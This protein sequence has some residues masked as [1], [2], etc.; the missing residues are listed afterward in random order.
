MLLQAPL[1]FV[2]GGVVNDNSLYDIN[3]FGRHW[4]KI[5]NSGMFAYNLAFSNSI[6]YSSTYDIR[7]AGISLRCVAIG[8]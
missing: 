8:S 3:S 7:K 2:R 1:Y 6:V 5:S 4:S